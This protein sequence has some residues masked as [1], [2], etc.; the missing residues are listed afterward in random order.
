[1]QRKNPLGRKK[2]GGASLNSLDLPAISEINLEQQVCAVRARLRP[3]KPLNSRNGPR[4]EKS[5][6]GGKSEGLPFTPGRK[7]RKWPPLSERHQRNSSAGGGEPLP[8]IAATMEKGDLLLNRLN[9]RKMGRKRGGEPFPSAVGFLGRSPE[10]RKRGLTS[11]LKP[12]MHAAS[13]PSI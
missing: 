1:M 10:S 8:L 2:G 7:K 12:Q 6:G 13:L 9:K 4:G 5:S 11:S 3:G